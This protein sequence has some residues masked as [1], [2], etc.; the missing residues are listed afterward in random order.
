MG[1]DMP[2]ETSSVVESA[3]ACI[4]VDRDDPRYLDLKCWP[5][6]PPGTN[7]FYARIDQVRAVEAHQR[8]LRLHRETIAYQDISPR[9]GA[10]GAY[11]WGDRSVEE[12]IA[13]A[14][15]LRQAFP[16]LI[17][18]K[19]YCADD[20]QH[21]ITIRPRETAVKRRHLQLNGK[22]AIV[23]MPF[24]VDRSGAFFAARDADLPAPNFIA[25]NRES[26]HAHVAYLLAG[27]VQQFDISRL[28]P[29]RYAADVQ[30]GLR[31]RL[32]ADAGYTGLISK[33]PLHPH[34]RVEWHDKP[35]DLGTLASHLSKADMRAE[36]RLQRE[37]GLGRN[38]S[39][40]DSL[41]YWAYSHVL[42][43]KLEGRSPREWFEQCVYVAEQHNVFGAPLSPS[44][45]RCI[46]KSVAKWTWARFDADK[47]CERQSRLGK[48]GLA[49]R[50]AGHEAE[51]TTKPWEAMGISRA[52]YYRNKKAMEQTTN[53]QQA[54]TQAA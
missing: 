18:P 33:N 24:D 38:C 21:G 13:S 34:W 10:R 35:Y 36:T 11:P 41:R 42:A 22:Q 28:E 9:R 30:R 47:F 43:A 15:G 54:K 39:V 49:K 20:P 50:W 6:V 19:P 16:S 46:A 4:E 14:S 8:E 2:S 44:E 7:P 45:I 27:P 12:I 37:T 51:S 32:G 25:A 1:T 48:R 40:F 31:R 26:G 3:R 5:K 29:I 53:V 23:W 52:T 17:P